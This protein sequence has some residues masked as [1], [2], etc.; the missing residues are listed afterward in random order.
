MIRIF[1]KNISPIAEIDDFISCIFQRNFYS[2]G[3]FELHLP[4]KKDYF[5]IFND[6][7]FIML[8][9][10][11]K[12]VGIIRN[13]EIYKDQNGLEILK[14]SGPNLKAIM[15]KRIILPPPNQYYDQQSGNQE[16]IM[17]NFVYNNFINTSNNRKIN[18]LYITENQ[19]LGSQDNWRSRFENVADKLEEIGVYSNLGWDVYLNFKEKEFIFDVIEGDDLTNS[20]IF[21]REFDNI[22]NETYLRTT[23]DR[24]SIIYAEDT[25]KNLIQVYGQGD[26]IEREEIYEAFNAT[27]FNDLDKLATRKLKEYDT[28]IS[29]D[30][31]YRE[32]NSFIYRKDFDLGDYITFRNFDW[33]LILKT[34]IIKITETIETG[35]KY[36]DLE[37]GDKVPTI[38]DKF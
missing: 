18:N 1:D 24:K 25:N 14:I 34:Q 4:M 12:K 20:V 10:D 8:E 15:K 5:E 36:I 29:L 26:G 27:D 21:S 2:I 6:D 13:I 32:S 37:Y 31:E 28:L 11:S 38:L 17:K 33:K 35:I 23:N 16:L 3:D 30:G 7:Y 19:N 9:N 22:Y